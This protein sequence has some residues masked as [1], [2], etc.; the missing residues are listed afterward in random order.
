MQ[1]RCARPQP[2]LKLGT[3][4]YSADSESLL[5][6]IVGLYFCFLCIFA[7]FGLFQCFGPVLKQPKQTELFLKKPKKSPKNA[8]YQDV[9]K[10]LVFFGSN[11]NSICFCCFFGVCGSQNFFLIC[12]GLFRCFGWVS[13]QPKKTKLMV[14]VIKKVYILTILLLFRLVF[15]LFRLLQN[16]ETPCFDIKTKQPKQTSCVGQCRNQFRLKF[17]LFRYE[18][19]FCGHP[20]WKSFIVVEFR[21]WNIFS[22]LSFR[23]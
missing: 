4:G 19:S 15:C 10:Q 20:S 3:V 16:T 5:S 9:S 8:L 18:T 13:K 17:R 1:N 11:R 23:N 2:R 6:A 21:K 12:F 14:W 22:I 7:F